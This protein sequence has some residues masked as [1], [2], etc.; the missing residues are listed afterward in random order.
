MRNIILINIILGNNFFLILNFKNA[1][2]LIFQQN[3][4]IIFFINNLYLEYWKI[5]IT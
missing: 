1:R 3:N 4:K 2:V 5:Q